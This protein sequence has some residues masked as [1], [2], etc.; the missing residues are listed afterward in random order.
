[1]NNIISKISLLKVVLSTMVVC[2][3]SPG[4]KKSEADKKTSMEVLEEVKDIQAVGK[5]V[6]SVADVVISSMVAGRINK[7]LVSEGDSVR[8]GQALL[9]MERGEADLDVQ[10]AKLQ[11]DRLGADLKVAQEEVRKAELVV[12]ERRQKYET[13]RR[14]LERN[15]ETKETVALDYSSLQQQESTLKGLKK[16]LE[17]QKLAMA[18][19]GIVVQKAAKQQ[20]ELLVSALGSG[21]VSDLNM[22]VGQ[23]VS[24]NEELGRIVKVDNPIVEAEVDELFANEVKIGQEVLIYP[25][26]N[27][28]EGNRGVIIYVNPILSNKSIFYE[29]ANEAQ[30]RR[31]RRIKIQI[32][33][34]TD[35]V[36]NTKVDCVIKIR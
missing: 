29:T 31:V 13:S 33:D 15:A 10:Q 19:Q 11:L 35:L 2:A 7:I 8:I 28:Q 14:L 17:S 3:C 30:D 22:S 5:I 20:K 12:D 34:R 6:P 21:I 23:Q 25:M 9:E 27:K 26:P 36:I 1:M 24:S 16:K 32:K 4:A 18:E